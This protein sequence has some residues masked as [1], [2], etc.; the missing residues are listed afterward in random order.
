MVTLGTPGTAG[1]KEV[2]RKGGLCRVRLEL[3]SSLLPETTQT[4]G[5][6]KSFITHISAG[7]ITRS[8]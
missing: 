8:A 5:F 7:K 2:G 3:N 6:L 1:R 4:I